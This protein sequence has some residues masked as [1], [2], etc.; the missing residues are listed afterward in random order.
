MAK[1][2]GRPRALADVADD[3]VVDALASAAGIYSDATRLLKAKGIKVSRRTLSRHIAD[4]PELKEA[5]DAIEASKLD[6][7]ETVLFDRVKAGDGPSTHFF[8]STKGKTRGYAKAAEVTVAAKPEPSPGF[9]DFAN[10]LSQNERRLLH[11]L[12][13]RAS[14][15][16]WAKGVWDDEL[17]QQGV[18]PPREVPDEQTR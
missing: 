2:I 7:A 10:G 12:M 13:V 14:G 18:L 4:R 16:K 6:L 8:L 3:V 15:K 1:K 5:L 9:V 17:V 11:S